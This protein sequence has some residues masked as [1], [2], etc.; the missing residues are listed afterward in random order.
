MNKKYIF[1]SICEIFLLTRNGDSLVSD[2]VCAQNTLSHAF[3]S[4]AQFVRVCCQAVIAITHLVWLKS[5]MRSAQQR[6]TFND[7]HTCT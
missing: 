5:K 1:I 2:G 4:C 6:Y 7:Q 3:C